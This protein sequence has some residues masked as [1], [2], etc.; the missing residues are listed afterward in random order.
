LF[1]FV[2]DG[3]KVPITQINAHKT[4]FKQLQ[5]GVKLNLKQPQKAKGIKL[6]RITR[7][8]DICKNKI[9]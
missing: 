5:N 8:E 2:L 4:R 9:T 1:N 3:L 7:R 6:E